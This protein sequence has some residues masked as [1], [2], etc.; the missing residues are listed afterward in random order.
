[1]S[2]FYQTICLISELI[3]LTYIDSQLCCN[4]ASKSLYIR[5]K[6]IIR[7]NS[8]SQ[9]QLSKLRKLPQSHVDK[10]IHDIFSF[11]LHTHYYIGID[12]MYS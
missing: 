12:N 3:I 10:T 5:N 7:N 9:S 4:S 11:L 8:N 6:L 2:V 1:M